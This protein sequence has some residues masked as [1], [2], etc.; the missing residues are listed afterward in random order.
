MNL[1]T[2]DFA[3]REIGCIA[4]HLMGLGFVPCSKHHTLTTGMH[5]NGKRRGE[6]F[7]VGLCDYHHQGKA[8]VGSVQAAALYK[9]R[10][11][12]YADNA[13][14]FRAKFPDHVL[15]AESKRRLELWEKN[16][17]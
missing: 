1:E 11:P 12:S 13:R 16:T 8:V 6:R 9:V 15:L 3:I 4:C 2:L 5:G 10:G 7:V 17:V 14:E